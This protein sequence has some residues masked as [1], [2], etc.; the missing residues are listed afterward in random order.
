MA[1]DETKT[2]TQG[3]SWPGL[4][5][6]L[7]VL[8]FVAYIPALRC[9]YIW[10]DDV[11]VTGNPFLTA[12]DG[13]QR[14]WFSPYTYP[15]YFPMVNTTL[16]FEYMLWGVNPAGYHFVNI[17]LHCLN[18]LLV[19]T[20]LRKLALPG[21]W[22]VAAIWAIHPVNV[23]SVA[24]ITELKNTQSTLFGLLTLLAWMK[25]T[26][27]HT[28]R[29]WRFY[30]LAFLL[31]GPA[32]FSKTTAST[33]P[34][35]MLLV[36]WLRKEPI[37]WRRFAQVVPFLCYGI[38][39]GLLSVWCE[40]HEGN[41]AEALRY[42]YGGVGRLLIATHALWFYAAKLAWPTQLTFSYP[43]WDINPRDPLQYLWL[44]ACVAVAL[45]LWW[46]RHAAGRGPV[47][48]VVFFVATLSPLLGFIP[49]YT[50][51]YSFVADHYQYVASIGLIALFVGAVSSRAD[52]WQLGR[53]LRF[54]L[55]ASLLLVLGALTWRQTAVYQNI[56]T[57]WR[58]TIA[59]N[60]R[61][62][63]AHNNLGL[64]LF[65]AGDIPAAIRE[66][67]QALQIEPNSAE[68]YNN[69]GISLSRLGRM[70]EAIQHYRRA[71][72]LSPAFPQAHDNL[73][74]ALQQIGSTPE[75]IQHFQQALQLKPDFAQAY[76]NLGNTLYQMGKTRDAIQLYEQAL[77]IKPDYAHAHANLA[78]ALL[79][80][81]QTQPAIEHYDQAL[82]IEPSDAETQNALA[83]LLA[84]LT[85]AEGGDPIRAATLAR[86]A[87]DL[88]HQAEPNYLDTLA[89]AFAAETH[90]SDAVVTAQKA[91]DLARSAGQPKL[92]EEIEAR[93]QLYREGRAYHESVS[94]PR[95]S[96]E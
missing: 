11:Y 45:L 12:P 96:A 27:R 58:D 46:R 88:T 9:G 14:I 73:G 15:A 3:V 72:L 89:A 82:R 24:W 31:Y 54:T 66:Y 22:L 94:V 36:L 41:Y 62:S 34:A 44:I 6:L 56:V 90:F 68:T 48:A 19:W 43:R 92:V 25:F 64:A 91:I 10:D 71:L 38:G 1:A 77:R 33:L 49:V 57:L 4:A 67:E 59:K 79:R 95:S 74:T 50:F 40:T 55:S 81:G 78:K 70:P 69:L 26:D 42:S 65:D 5:I 21:S 83:W 17:L 86:Q 51:R 61:S 87:C 23:E 80:L 75:A 39:I 8:T 52:A 84:T 35:T 32:L 60:P 76:S 13:L 30:A 28:A 7:V 29:P 18:V 20:V 85:P 37:G 16:R 63:M 2:E 53:N 93:L 47:A